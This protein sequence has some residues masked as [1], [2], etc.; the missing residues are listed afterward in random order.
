MWQSH[1]YSLAWGGS[2]LNIIFHSLQ[3]KLGEANVL[4]CNGLVPV[5]GQK[6]VSLESHISEDDCRHQVPIMKLLK[7]FPASEEPWMRVEQQ[8]GE[9]CRILVIVALSLRDVARA[10]G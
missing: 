3:T 1:C 9:Q 5:C 10:V 4:R 8:P 7:Y 2:E 6:V